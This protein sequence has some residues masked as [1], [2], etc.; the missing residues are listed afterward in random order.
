MTVEAG[1]LGF[2]YDIIFFDELARWED[3]PE[4]LKIPQSE[5]KAAW[6][7]FRAKR[8]LPVETKPTYRPI[9]GIPGGG[10]PAGAGADPHDGDPD[11]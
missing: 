6:E 4:F 5:R 3:I 2:E 1:Y 11:A 7:K 8:P 10:T 9:T